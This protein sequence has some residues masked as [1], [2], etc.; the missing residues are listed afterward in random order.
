MTTN[1]IDPPMDEFAMAN[2]SQRTAATVAGIAGL[3]AFSL[4]VFGNY[5]LLEPLLVPRSAVDTARNQAQSIAG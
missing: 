1:K 4:V 5:V 3:V 2:N